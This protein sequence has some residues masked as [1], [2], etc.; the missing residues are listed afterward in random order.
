MSSSNLPDELWRQILEIGIR[1]SKFTYKDLCCISISCRRLRRLSSED[2]LWSH[3]LFSDFAQPFT[4]SAKSV[5]KIRYEKEKG[6]KLAA[7]RRAVLRAESQIMERQRRTVEIQNLLRLETQK[8]RAAANEFSNLHKIRQASL[9]LNVWQPEVI[10]SRQKQMVEQCSVPVESRLH[11]LEM[12]LK[13]CKHQISGFK[14]AYRDEIQR[15][16]TAKQE[17]ASLKYHPLRDY[18]STDICEGGEC[19]KRRKKLKFW[20]NAPDP[21]GNHH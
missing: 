7:H 15:L 19:N 16:E 5:Y 14:K 13:L 3:L 1:N 9:A 8:M 17:L 20:I 2:S 4:A 18:K 12:E 11:S 21:D 6:R 10:R